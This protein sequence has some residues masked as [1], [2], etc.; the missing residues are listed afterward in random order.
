MENNKF[1]ATSCNSTDSLTCIEGYAIDNKLCIKCIGENTKWC[2]TDDKNIAKGCKDGYA[3]KDDK[4]NNKCTDA[5]AKECDSTGNLTF[6]CITGWKL[7]GTGK[8][9]T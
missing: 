9:C 2:K 5:G 6:E 1:I 4:C 7:I 3:L 8:I